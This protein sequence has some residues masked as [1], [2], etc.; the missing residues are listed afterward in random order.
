MVHVQRKEGREERKDFKIAA[1]KR[2]KAAVSG[3]GGIFPGNI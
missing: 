1:Y 2:R 3:G